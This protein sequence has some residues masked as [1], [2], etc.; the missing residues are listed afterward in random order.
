MD[1]IR[2]DV[3]LWAARFY[4][5]RSL[6]KQAVDGGQVTVNGEPAKP[7]TS[8]RSG[9][10][11]RA[12]LGDSHRLARVLALS[13]TR[14]PAATARLLYAD[15]TPPP[16]PRSGRPADRVAGSGRPTKRDRRETDRW[17]GRE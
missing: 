13:S 7:S 15:L 9:D 3:W 17:R 4:K 2:L 11:V 16:P 12:R 14:G 10:E 5:T 8:L 1:A 6:A